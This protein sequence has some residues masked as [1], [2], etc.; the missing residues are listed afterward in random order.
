ML[1]NRESDVIELLCS[2]GY[3]HLVWHCNRGSTLSLVQFSTLLPERNGYF[4][5]VRSPNAAALVFEQLID[6]IDSPQ[7][8]QILAYDV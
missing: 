6:L 5:S 2:L 4:K 7:Y 8:R 3:L 1:S